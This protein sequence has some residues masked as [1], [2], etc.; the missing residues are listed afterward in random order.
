MI[1]K[2]EDATTAATAENNN[3]YGL[4]KLKPGGGS[5]SRTCG[6]SPIIGQF[7][8]LALGHSRDQELQIWI[9]PC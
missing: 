2:T 6:G 8:F 4:M 9:L 3:S 7:L 1:T 5:H